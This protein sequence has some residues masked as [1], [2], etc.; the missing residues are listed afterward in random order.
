MYVDVQASEL[1]WRGVYW[2][3]IGF[4]NPRPIALVAT[5]ASDG[6]HNLAPFSFYNMVSANPPVVMICPA[7]RRDGSP[8]DTLR[9]I[10]ETGQ[11]VVATV[12]EAIGEAMAACG[13]DLPYGESEFEF[14]G[15]T[16]APARQVRPPLV[17]ESPVNIECNL[18]QTVSFGTQPGAGT[19]VFGDI[20]AVHVADWLLDAQGLV[21]PHKLRT[22]GRLGENW[23]CR[24]VEPFELHVPK[25]DRQ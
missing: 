7:P 3:C 24:V 25:V 20:L 9:N 1:D 19:A 10:R 6:R 13:A 4:I 2:L 12:T 11:F 15:L 14:S 22:L 17:R 23:Y 5:V 8:K 16:P 21:D 18:R